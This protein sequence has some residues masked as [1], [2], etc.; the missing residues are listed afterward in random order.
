MRYENSNVLK[1][2]EKMSTISKTRSN[3]RVPVIVLLLGLSSPA[4][5]SQTLEQAVASALESHPK[6][7]ESF[8]RYKSSEQSI[9]EARAGYYPVLDAN[10]GIGYEQSSSPGIRRDETTDDEVGLTRRELGLSLRQ[11]IFDG[12]RT[13]QEVAQAENEANAEQWTLLATAEDQALEVTR[14]YLDVLVAKEVVKL[15]EKNLDNHE[16]I[17]NLIKSNHEGG[18]SKSSDVSQVKGRLARANAN[19]L[20]A[21]NNLAD[22]RSA[23]VKMVGAPPEA[24]RFP[25]PDDN[26]LPSSLDN[27][28]DI[29]LANHP[30]LKAAESGIIAAKAA[31]KASNAANLPTANFEVD[32]N[33]NDNVGGQDGAGSPNVGGENKNIQAMLRMRYNLFNGGADSARKKQAAYKLIEAREANEM[34]H[35]QVVDSATITWNAK[36]YLKE[37]LEYINEHVDAATDTREDYR[38]EFRV[39]AR[40]L[41]D[42]LG[43][44]NEL[45]EARRDAL[46]KQADEIYAQYRMLNVTGQLLASLRVDMPTNWDRES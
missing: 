9:S 16:E 18:F 6:I 20:S 43:A 39:N 23:F 15:A 11:M 42:V 3:M 8:A 46:K 45:F 32:A 38:E 30:R 31:R 36:K 21:R 14:T 22:E 35:R 25:N 1:G 13:N 2:G 17:F 37:Q 29:A 44:E 27:A 28:I 33:W 41:L 19:L 26:L 5:L 40:T 10:A 34:I 7:R 24:L 4:V 12:F